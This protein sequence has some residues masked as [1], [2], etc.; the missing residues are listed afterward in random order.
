MP[1]TTHSQV[2]STN[3]GAMPVAASPDMAADIAKL[4]GAGKS[5]Q[6][7]AQ[8][9]AIVVQDA[10]DN[11]RNVNTISTTALGVAMAQFLETGDMKYAQ[12]ID[13]AHK[14]SIDATDVFKKSGTDAADIIR[15]Y[16]S[17]E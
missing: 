7:I 15:G 16:P 4:E 1:D 5:F 13:L 12:A 9:A 14:I 6:S 8:S 2:P 11:L 17:G 10:T 3:S